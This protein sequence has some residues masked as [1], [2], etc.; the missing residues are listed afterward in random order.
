MCIRINTFC[1]NCLALL[2][3]SGCCPEKQISDS[4]SSGS[5]AS[6]TVK[7]S[8]RGEA[9]AAAVRAQYYDASG[10]SAASGAGS[11]NATSVNDS[12][13]ISC[14]FTTD[15]GTVNTSSTGIQIVTGAAPSASSC[16]NRNACILCT[17]ATSG[18]NCSIACTGTIPS[19]SATASD[20]FN[21]YVTYTSTLT[22]NM[23]Y[24]GGMLRVSGSISSWSEFAFN[25]QT[26]S[27]TYNAASAVYSGC[28]D[29][30]SSLSAYTG[31]GAVGDALSIA[32]S[33]ATSFI[34]DPAILSVGNGTCTLSH[35][36]KASMPLTG[37]ATPGATV[38]LTRGSISLTSKICNV[39]SSATCT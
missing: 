11:G 29:G 21:V 23:G 5:E 6:A 16:T 2:M 26:N 25:G 7:M 3:F 32:T 36:F 31:S 34:Q 27:P 9:L 20:S 8:G 4:D 35:Q 18:N 22:T 13:S 28:K 33:G 39:Q 37:A 17:T 19:N 1:I 14:A 24:V 30:G 12:V 10:T 15:S 38:S